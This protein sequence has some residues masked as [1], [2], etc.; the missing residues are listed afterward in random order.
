MKKLYFLIGLSFFVCSLMGQI[1]VELNRLNVITDV[2]G[3][4]TLTDS[5]VISQITNGASYNIQTSEY[6]DYLFWFTIKNLDGSNK[7]YKIRKSNE[8][9]EDP[10]S[11]V[12]LCSPNTNNSTG[13]C[14]L[15]DETASFIIEP[16]EVAYTD[17]S[18]Y[19]GANTTA[20]VD[21]TLFLGTNY[22]FAGPDD[23]I[24]FTLNFSTQTVSAPNRNIT[25]LS[26]YP[27]PATSNFTVSG[28]FNE[29]GAVEVYNI[30]GKLVYKTNVEKGSNAVSINCDKWE[31]SYYLV[32]F[33]NSKKNNN[34]L[35]LVV[36]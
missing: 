17:I 19:N 15:G 9:L 22:T 16:N 28:E 8:N 25:N 18:Y 21:I 14:S 1:N 34:P 30:I 13:T 24:T 7:T 5:V 27:N 10:T 31:K 6:K 32:R 35:K 33:V 26:L 2:N 4:Y 11:R 29:N 3:S 12:Q 23:K 36:K 20:S